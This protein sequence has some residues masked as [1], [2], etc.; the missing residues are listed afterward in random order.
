MALMPYHTPF[1][2]ISNYFK[3]NLLKVQSKRSLSCGGLRPLLIA[4]L[5]LLALGLAACA[6]SGNAA[7]T[8]TPV[9]VDTPTPSAAVAVTQTETTTTAQ[10]SPSAVVTQIQAI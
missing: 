6:G 8:N 2:T 7:P 4:S 5:L 9:A 1:P 3:E 10:V